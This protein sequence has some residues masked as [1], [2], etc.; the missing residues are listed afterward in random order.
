MRDLNFY[1]FKSLFLYDT[2]RY[3]KKKVMVAIL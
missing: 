3:D 2:I 1:S